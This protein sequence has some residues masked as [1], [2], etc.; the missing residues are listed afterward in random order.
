MIV[1]ISQPN[2]RGTGKAGAT[3]VCHAARACPGLPDRE[4]WTSVQ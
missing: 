1:T 3:V 2:N 4:R